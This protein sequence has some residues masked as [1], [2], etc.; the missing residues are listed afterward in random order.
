MAWRHPLDHFKLGTAFGVK[1]N[2]H[3]NGHKGSDYNGVPE[4]TPVKAIN[5]ATITAVNHSDGLGWQIQLHT[6]GHNFWTYSHLHEKPHLKVG[7]KVKAGDVVGKL[8]NTGKY[9]S[10]PHLHITLGESK[11]TINGSGKLHDAHGFIAQREGK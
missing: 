8:G 2:L 5:D 3:P 9:S 4:G 10:G 11:E 7:D 6:D 1:D